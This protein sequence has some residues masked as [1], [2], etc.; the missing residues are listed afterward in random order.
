M[1]E[2]VYVILEKRLK[3]EKTFIPRWIEAIV[4]GALPQNVLVVSQSLFSTMNTIWQMLGDQSTGMQWY[5][6]RF[7]I[8][9]IF[10]TTEAFMVH[11]GSA[12]FAETWKLLESQL[13]DQNFD[14][15]N[16]LAFL[17]KKCATGALSYIYSNRFK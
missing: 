3:Y 15:L 16:D 13:Q 17:W 8:G 10:V 7:M 11:D 5:V 1:N 2:Q 12:D 6:K 14:E 4:L 9:Q